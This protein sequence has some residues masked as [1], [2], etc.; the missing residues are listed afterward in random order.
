MVEGACMGSKLYFYAL[1]Q[2]KGWRPKMPTR[3]AFL[4]GMA[5]A[6]AP[7]WAAYPKWDACTD[8][9]T[10]A[11]FS[12]VEL[13]GNAAFNTNEPIKMAFDLV[14]APGEDAKDKVD[15][16]FVERPGKVRRYDSK[17]KTV[18]ELGKM[19]TSVSFD[20]VLA[21]SEGLSGIAMDPS[22]K[23]NHRIYLYYSAN[24]SNT[25]TWNVSR[26]TLNADNTKIDFTSEKVL[27]KIPRTATKHPGGAMT[28]DGYGDLWITVGDNEAGVQT[29]A[30]TNDLRGKILRIH[31]K[32]DGT[33]SIP[34][35]NLYPVGTAKTKPEVYIMG[36]RHPYSIA[37]DPVRRWVAW[38]DVG[39]DSK[40]NPDGSAALSEESDLATAPGN[41]GYPFFAGNNYVMD[42]TVKVKPALPIL[43]KGTDW[44]K[45]SPGL[46][47][48]KPAIPAM[49]F[50]NQAC[51]ITGPIYRYDGLLNSSVK[52]PPHFD[53]KWM[54]TD[55]DAPQKNVMSVVTLSADGK[56]KVS[57][58]EVFK[59]ITLY[60]PLDFQAGPDG[61]FYVLNY[62][63]Y[64]T[65]TEQTG[66]IRISYNGSCRPTTPVLETVGNVN[67]FA[68]HSSRSFSGLVLQGRQLVVTAPGKYSVELRDLQGRQVAAYRGE[69]PRNHEITAPHAG[70]YVLNLKNSQGNQS[71]P[72]F[73]P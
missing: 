46:D 55:F 70:V 23:T 51:A 48:L 34:D 35:G 19:P 44:G 56:T 45:T 11:N 69:G 67:T 37:V 20:F 28:F 3:L 53:H 49:V 63:G 68:S 10:D 4:T 57:Q 16:Y 47:T 38:G 17:A 59:N 62:A 60:K 66:I 33:Y 5:L 22:F 25:T 15:I 2:K 43:P 65:V 64:R 52:M 24:V 6:V 50:Y 31:P 40:K 39:P 58:D 7:S 32:E 18:V 36:N 41:Y 30:N 14:A 27:L 54:L 72:V 8:P 29:S 26:F 42:T 73:I 13:V 12:S 9:L 61:A 21:E 1:G 71:L